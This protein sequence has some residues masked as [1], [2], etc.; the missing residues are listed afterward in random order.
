MGLRSIRE[1]RARLLRDPEMQRLFVERPE[2]LEVAEAFLW[3][4]PHSP[5]RSRQRLRLVVFLLGFGVVWVLFAR[6]RR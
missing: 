4:Y 5:A 6:R 3:S 1:R 2:V